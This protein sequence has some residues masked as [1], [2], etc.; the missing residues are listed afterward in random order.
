MNKCFI[1]G[2]LTRD[3]EL[4]STPNGIAVCNF[5][6][7]VNRRRAA[8][9]EAS[10]GPEADFFRVTAWR[11]LGENCNRYLAKGR[12]VAVVGSVQVSTYTAQDGATRAS[13]DVMADDVEFLSPRGDESGNPSA[14]YQASN[15]SADTKGGFVKVEDEELPF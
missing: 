3:P 10:Q 1:I 8:G 7:A 11:Q 4:R 15:Q 2:N 13:L 9:A 14:S 12:K 6:V 5:T